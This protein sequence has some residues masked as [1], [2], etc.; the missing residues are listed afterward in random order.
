MAR[1]QVYKDLVFCILVCVSMCLHITYWHGS[2]VV[3]TSFELGKSRVLI[4][5]WSLL[6][7]N[8]V[9]VA[10]LT[11]TIFPSYYRS[12]GNFED[13]LDL[14]TQIVGSEDCMT[15]CPTLKVN[16]RLAML[17]I[18]DLQWRQAEQISFDPLQYNAIWKKHSQEFY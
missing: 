15:N 17:M 11:N 7:L 9:L 16:V 13:L 4:L 2:S 1:A 6:I 12:R 3:R 10:V 5:L 8:R 18:I 14:A